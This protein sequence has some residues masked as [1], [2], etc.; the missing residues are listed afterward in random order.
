MNDVPD[1]FKT[2]RQFV[3]NSGLA[4]QVFC[5]AKLKQISKDTQT[6]ATQNVNYICISMQLHICLWLLRFTSDL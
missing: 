4:V 6:S 5:Y 1:I 3:I 2:I